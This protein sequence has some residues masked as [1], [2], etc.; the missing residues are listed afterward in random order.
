[1]AILAAIVVV[2][3]AGSLLGV[4]WY[5]ASEIEKGGLLVD[6]SRSEPNLAVI[7]IGDGTVELKRT[8]GTPRLDEPGL[9]GLQGPDGYG[10]VSRVFGLGRDTVIREFSLLSGTI[11]AGDAVRFDR[12][13]FPDNPL[14][15]HGLQYTEVTIDSPVGGLPAWHVAGTDDTWAILVHGRRTSRE[16]TLRA[17]GTISKAGL[18]ALAVS[19][20]NDPGLPADPSGYYRFG[21]TEWEDLEAAARYALDHG[22][23]DLVIVGFSMGG[24][25]AA[26]FMYNSELA[27]RVSGVV[28]DSPMLDFGRTVDLAAGQRGLPQF[29]AATSKWLAAVRFDV[30]WSEMDYLADV[31]RLQVPALVFHG[32][33]D[34]TVPFGTSEEFAHRRPD[35]VRFV[36]VEGAVHVGS[37]NLAPDV[38][39]LELR[40]FIAHLIN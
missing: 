12:D 22:A 34:P 37:W 3:L 1:V 30:D 9:M 19:Y 20:R 36:P 16:E 21:V 27:A 40:D 6:H 2:I 14:I 24:G 35:I 31:D 7:A 15:A 8:R 33:A 25:I 18:P 29:V 11:N 32:D 4:G 5:Y 13:A 26:S 28:F 23:R 39:E 10:R 17:L 38:Y